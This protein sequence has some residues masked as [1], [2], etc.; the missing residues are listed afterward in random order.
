MSINNHSK[1][2]LYSI[3]T[4]ARMLG[5]SVASLRLYER[6]GL[7]LLG[8]SSGNQRLF[9]EADIERIRC[10]RR[11]IT[12]DK[13]GIEGIRRLHSL[14]PCWDIIGCTESDQA[15]CRAFHEHECGCWTYPH[16]HDICGSRECRTCSVYE[17]A[18]DCGN[19][20]QTIIKASKRH[21]RTVS[22]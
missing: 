1:R 9:S 3:G 13:I 15:H 8:K 20:K 6:M 7:I 5:I 19:I 11:A 17:L 21:A 2:P 4:A 14:I 18:V 16:E 12:E 22:P 10:I